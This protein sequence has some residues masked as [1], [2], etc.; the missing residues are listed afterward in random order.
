MC[1]RD[2]RETATQQVGYS[3]DGKTAEKRLQFLESVGLQVEPEPLE[4]VEVKVPSAF[5]DTYTCLLY[6]SR[7]V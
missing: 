1:I 2:S 6:T 5:D 3:L 7:C 4:V